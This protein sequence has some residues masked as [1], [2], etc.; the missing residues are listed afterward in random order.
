M[1]QALLLLVLL[2]ATV[3]SAD[4]ASFGDWRKQIAAADDAIKK[5]D[6]DKAREILE[7]AAPEAERHGPAS[8]AENSTRLGSVLH[9]MRE[10]DEALAVLNAALEKIGAQPVSDKLQIW[11]GALLANKAYTLNSARRYDDAIP[12]ANDAIAVLEK[13]AGKYH[14]DL[15]NLQWALADIHMAKKNFEL[16]EKHLKAALKLAET[17]QV[18]AVPM[19]GP[20]QYGVNLYRTPTADDGIVFINTRLGNLY[21]DMKRYKE[22]ED[23]LKDALKVAERSFG[24]KHIMTV[25]PLRGMAYLHRATDR[26]K[27]FDADLDRIYEIATKDQGLALNSVDPFWLQLS[28]DLDANNSAAI[29]R[30]ADRIVTIYQKQNFEPQHL[31]ARASGAAGNDWTKVARAQEALRKSIFAKFASEPVKVGQVVLDFGAA[32]E[33]GQQPELARANYEAFIAAQEKAQDQSLL[34]GGLGKLADLCVSENKPADALP[35]RQRMTQLLRA[36]YGDDT[37]VAD[38]LD[39]ESALQTKLGKTDEAEKLKAQAQEVRTKAFLKR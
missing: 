21:S 19:T 29:E 20:D 2:S 16:E 15:Y 22:S 33:K 37:R 12:V 23:A 27:E 8:S 34:I 13:I 1:K 14:P 3:F 38:S 32:A 7:A 10:Y 5:R 18:Y 26:K 30:T 4:A 25:G 35:L 17:R 36:K 24:K 9:K 6:F 28:A 31:T 39:A 11:R